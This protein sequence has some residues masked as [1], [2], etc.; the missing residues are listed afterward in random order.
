MD[1]PIHPK[2]NKKPLKRIQVVGGSKQLLR[3]VGLF[4]YIT[5]LQP[6]MVEGRT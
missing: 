4:I 2:A 6:N 1:T 5:T 3:I